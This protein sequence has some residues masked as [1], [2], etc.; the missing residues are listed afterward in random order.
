MVSVPYA[1]DISVHLP[2]QPINGIDS[3]SLLPGIMYIDCYGV[4][5]HC[6][7]DQTV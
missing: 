7:G 3:T 5:G 2:K 4:G 6:R 1:R